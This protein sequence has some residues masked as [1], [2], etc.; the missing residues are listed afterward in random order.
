MSDYFLMNEDA[1]KIKA[2]NIPTNKRIS[3]IKLSPLSLN[4]K[5]N[6]IMSADSTTS[7]MVFAIDSADIID[8]H[9]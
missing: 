4:T 7:P 1:A 8:H 6:I 2:N 9:V 5:L 3:V